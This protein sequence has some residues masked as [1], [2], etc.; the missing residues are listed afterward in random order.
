LTDRL[1]AGDVER[2]KSFPDTVRDYLRQELTNHDNEVRDA[3]LVRV[4]ELLGR[5]GDDSSPH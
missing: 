3:V 2:G 4:E 5:C 1:T